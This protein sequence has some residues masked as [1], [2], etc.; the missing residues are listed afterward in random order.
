MKKIIRERD[1]IGFYIKLFPLKAHPDAYKKSKAIVCEKSLKLYDEAIAGQKLPAP[2]CE[3]TEVDDNIKLAESL[4][5]TG[6]PALILPDGAIL[7]GYKDAKD[8]I[9]IIDESGKRAEAE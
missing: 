4:G 2:T 8:L 1:D 7:P 6:T 3:T 9:Q 5:I